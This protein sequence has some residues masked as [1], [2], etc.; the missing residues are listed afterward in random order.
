MFQHIIYWP[1]VLRLYWSSFAYV[2]VYNSWKFSATRFSPFSSNMTN[3]NRPLL[4]PCPCLLSLSLSIYLYSF[5]VLWRL[6]TST[7]LSSVQYYHHY[8]LFVVWT[9]KR[10]GKFG[11]Y[12][13][14]HQG[15]SVPV[16][17]FCVKLCVEDEENEVIKRDTYFF[18]LS[19]WHPPHS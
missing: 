13:T 5:L 14:R 8:S 2:R 3:F 7:I 11:C 18:S 16:D 6:S 4:I 15:S 9:R 17:L 10:K 12:I 19:V 1:L